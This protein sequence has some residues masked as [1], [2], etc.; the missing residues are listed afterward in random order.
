MPMTADK[1]AT[2]PIPVQLSEAEFNKFIQTPPHSVVGFRQLIANPASRWHNEPVTDTRMSSW[3]MGLSA[4]D[5]IPARK[6]PCWRLAVSGA[7]FAP[8]VQAGTW[9][10]RRL[11]WWRA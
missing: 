5:V 9:P 7:A 11:T 10:R 8:P 6:R 2:T 3:P 1:P 4:W